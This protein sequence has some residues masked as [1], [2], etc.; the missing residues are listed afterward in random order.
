MQNTLPSNYMFNTSLKK[1]GVLFSKTELLLW[2]DFPSLFFFSS[3][4]IFHFAI[5]PVLSQL[6]G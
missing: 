6:T 1:C 3:N 2:L 5:F 4:G